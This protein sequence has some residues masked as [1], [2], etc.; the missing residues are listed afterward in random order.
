MTE[1]E[2]DLT[3]E[4]WSKLFGP[5]EHHMAGFWSALNLLILILCVMTVAVSPAV[6]IAVWRWLL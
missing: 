4:S 5:Q 3:S 1:P 2:A 6:V